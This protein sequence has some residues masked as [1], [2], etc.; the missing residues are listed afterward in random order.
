[1]RGRTR[2]ILFRPTLDRWRLCERSLNMCVARRISM[3]LLSAAVC[4][5]LAVA[6]PAHAAPHKHRAARLAADAET[7]RPGERPAVMLERMKEQIL[8][9]DLSAD[10]K[11]KIDELFSKAQDELAAERRQSGEKD[12]AKFREKAQTIIRE[13]R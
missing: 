11:Q 7:P 4:A 6:L 3:I 9:M 8:S 12:L 2:N 5:P 1:M 13:L 10:Q